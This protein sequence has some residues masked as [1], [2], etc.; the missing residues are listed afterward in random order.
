MARFAVNGLLAIALGS[1]AYAATML[2]VDYFFPMLLDRTTSGT[3]DLDG[4]AA[5]V[6]IGGG[7]FFLLMKRFPP[8]KV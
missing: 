1:C 4:L 3:G 8:R 6:I 2:T 5:L 7:T